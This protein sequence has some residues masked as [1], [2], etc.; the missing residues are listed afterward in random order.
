M[1]LIRTRRTIT[2][3]IAMT[4][5]GA[6]FFSCTQP[7]PNTEALQAQV[8]RLQQRLDSAYTPGLGEFMSGIQVHHEKLWFT[9]KAT[10]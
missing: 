4:A 2:A 1:P 8:Q 9:S 5:L 10:N 6:L 7:G 3:F